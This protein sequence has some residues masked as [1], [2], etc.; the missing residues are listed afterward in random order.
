[1]NASDFLDGMY[2]EFIH[3]RWATFLCILLEVKMLSYIFNLHLD[4][5][6]QSRVTF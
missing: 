1:M 5:H 6:W 2:T 4:I 3:L